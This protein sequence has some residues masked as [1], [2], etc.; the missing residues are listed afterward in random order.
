MAQYQFNKQFVVDMTYSFKGSHRTTRR[1]VIFSPSMDSI[2]NH[3]ELHCPLGA[4]PEAV[5][6]VEEKDALA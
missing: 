2:W 6:L 1:M 3:A 5:E 4:T